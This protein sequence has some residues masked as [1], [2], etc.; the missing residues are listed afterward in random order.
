M[1]DGS[2]PSSVAETDGPKLFC[3]AAP[4]FTM[5]KINKA[6]NSLFLFCFLNLSAMETVLMAGFHMG[7][8][9]NMCLFF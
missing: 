8:F 9:K 7:L 6:I 5:F 4:M 2:A 1:T 3:D